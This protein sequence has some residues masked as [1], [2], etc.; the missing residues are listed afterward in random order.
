MNWTKHS[1]LRHLAKIFSKHSMVLFVVAMGTILLF[2]SIPF[3]NPWVEL[4]YSQGLFRAFR[5]I[6]DY[7]LGWS[8]IPLIYLLITAIIVW[9]YRRLKY[10]DTSRKWPF[11]VLNGVVTLTSLGILLF[12]WTWGF[13]Y[14][15]PALFD[16]L[17]VPKYE[18]NEEVLFNELER[19]TAHLIDLR[20][21]LGERQL[22]VEDFKIT[23]SDLRLS[24][25]RVYRLLE[26]NFDGRPRIR[27]LY[28][29]GSLLHIST[30]GVY[31][32]FVGEGH[33]DPGLHPLTW[34][35][36]S[37]HEMAHVQGQTGEDVCNFLALLACVNDK[38]PAV[39]YSG[40]FSYWRYLRANAY[41]AN[42]SRYESYWAQVDGRLK[43][44]LKDVVDYANRYPDILPKLRDLFYDN[45]LK[46]HGISEGLQ[47][48]SRIIVLSH[49][50]QEHFGSLKDFE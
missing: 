30:A 25:R 6:W 31:L 23:E 4:F 1:I 19:V 2:V 27:K 50:W 44:D 29:K 11:R 9:S 38:N 26:L 18:P 36:T 3:D 17:K 21:Q 10:P 49:S 15:R 42:S 35:F 41:R 8:P 47:S 32:P 34:P 40:W 5:I 24:L 37:I 20:D 33:I 28:P 48:Y 12:Y 43:Q 13:N 45:Y 7:T 16:T 46:S 22:K 14:K 39:Q